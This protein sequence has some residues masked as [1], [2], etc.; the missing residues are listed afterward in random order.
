MTIND[1]TS[2]RGE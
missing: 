1:V 2:S